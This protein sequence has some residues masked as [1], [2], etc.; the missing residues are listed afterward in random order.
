MPTLPTFCITGKLD[1]REANYDEMS[2]QL[3]HTE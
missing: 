3:A 1:S 2:K